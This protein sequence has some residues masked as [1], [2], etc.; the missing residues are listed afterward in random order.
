VFGK[1]FYCGEQ[2]GL[3]QSMKLAN[4]F[5]SATGMAASSEAI[6]MGVKAG[7]TRA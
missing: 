3:A 1:V 5:L 2:A 4:N 7:S 6:A